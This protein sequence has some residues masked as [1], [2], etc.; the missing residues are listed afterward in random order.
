MKIAIGADHAGFELKDKIKQV[1]VQQGIEVDDK[2]TSSNA[3]V[4]YPDYARKVGEEVAHA[5]AD[6]GILVCGS[7]IGMEIAANK[8][9]GVRAANAR[10]ELDAQLSRE[11]NNANVL[12]LGAR[13]LDEATALKIIDKWLHTEFAGGRHQVRVGKI[14]AI[15][16]D[17]AKSV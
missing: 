15:E 13:M 6:R 5:Q 9:P 11:H 17:E 14:S 8:V 10:T 16:R 1:L 12:T 2:G 4:D 7:G 3:S